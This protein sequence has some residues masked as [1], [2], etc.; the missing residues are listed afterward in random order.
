MEIMLIKWVLEVTN[1][2][3]FKSPHD[4]LS[5]YNIVYLGC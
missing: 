1:Q 4:F 3:K 2:E 5:E